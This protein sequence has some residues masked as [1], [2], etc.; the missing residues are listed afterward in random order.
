MNN[1][2]EEQRKVKPK[3]PKI[4]ELLDKSQ[5]LILGTVD[6]NG[7]PLASYA[8]YVLVD[9]SFR[10]LVSFMAK[11]TKNLRDRN[12]ASVMFID[13]ESATKQVYARDRLTIA[14]ESSQIENGT[15]A[16]TKSVDGLK[17]RH[18][19]VVEML[20]ELNDF[21]MI[22]LKPLSG[23]YVNGFGSAYSVNAD[24]SINEHVRGAHGQHTEEEQK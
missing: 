17:E 4:E 16:W 8:P 1:I 14:C 3:A 11:H 6:E 12:K 15:E 23:S 21:I 9:G 5:S 2:Q 19:K 7:N 24:L 10:I 22:E 13:D 18:G 20:S